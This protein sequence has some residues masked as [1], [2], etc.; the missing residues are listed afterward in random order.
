MHLLP[1]IINSA[2]SIQ[3]IRRN[4]HA[5]P[6]LRFEENRTGDLVAEALSSWGIS[7][8]RGM[9]KTGVVGRLDGDLG[10]GKMIGLRADMDALPLQEHNN[11]EHTSRNPGKMHAC[12]HDG[13]TAMLLGAAQYLSN[14]RDFK[15]TVIFIFQPA[16]EGGAGAKEM[17][18]DGLFKEFPCDAVF[19][20]I[21]LI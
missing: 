6:E 21:M 16:E 5:H 10:P 14:H 9:G 4:I 12:G 3:D 8:Y 7:V 17:I 18:Q 2:K 19:G 15:G 20:C 13:H 1:E 11:F